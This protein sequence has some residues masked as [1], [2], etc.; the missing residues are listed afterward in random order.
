MEYPDGSMFIQRLPVIGSSYADLR[1]LT[2]LGPEIFF[3]DQN[4]EIIHDETVELPVVKTIA[5]PKVGT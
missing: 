3:L 5:R 2:A 1:A 4:D